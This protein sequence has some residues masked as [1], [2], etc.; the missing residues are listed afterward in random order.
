MVSRPGMD[1]NER[2]SVSTHANFVSRNH[3][4]PNRYPIAET[5]RCGKVVPVLARL[6][7]DQVGPRLGSMGL[8]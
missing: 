3:T 5:G 1:L 4:V 6:F 8:A 2:L 7:F